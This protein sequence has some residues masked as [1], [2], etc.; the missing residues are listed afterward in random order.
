MTETEK[1]RERGVGG[2]VELG[3]GG[4]VNNVISQK[5]S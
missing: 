5:Y 1:E 2:G 3:G 4:V